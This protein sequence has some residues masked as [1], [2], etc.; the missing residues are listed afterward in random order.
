M[1]VYIAGP[2][3]GIKDYRERFKKAK[4]LLEEKGYQVINPAELCEILPQ[5][6][7]YEEYMN[8]CMDSLLPMCDCMALLPGWEKSPGANREYGWALAC[9]RIVMPLKDFVM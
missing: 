2:I 6:T 9:D 1:R 4:E 8:V 5:D 3:T 7:K